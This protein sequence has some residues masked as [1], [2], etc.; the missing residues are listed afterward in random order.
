MKSRSGN[1]SKVYTNEGG[2]LGTGLYAG[3]VILDTSKIEDCADYGGMLYELKKLGIQDGEA[4]QIS[5]GGVIL[6][7]RDS[8]KR[9]KK[10]L[11]KFGVTVANL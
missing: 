4:Y 8:Y 7:Y 3:I 1:K 11:K 10:I 6:M 2:I 5:N 9:C